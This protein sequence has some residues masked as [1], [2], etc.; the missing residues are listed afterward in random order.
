V[1]L[2]LQRDPGHPQALELRE[3]WTSPGRRSARSD[4]A[5]EDA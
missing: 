5:R 2:V 4:R 3:R 1:A